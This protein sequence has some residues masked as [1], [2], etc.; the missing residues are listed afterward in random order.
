MRRLKIIRSNVIVF[1]IIMVLVV[2]CSKKVTKP[3]EYE[4]PLLFEIFKQFE[5]YELPKEYVDFCK[6]IWNNELKNDEKIKEN[7]WMK[8]GYTVFVYNHN[9]FADEV[10]RD[11]NE[12]IFFTTTRPVGKENQIYST[13]TPFKLKYYPDFEAEKLKTY[14]FVNDHDPIESE[15]EA[16]DLMMKYL[17]QYI[18]KYKDGYNE[19][20]I[21]IIK[22]YL[23]YYNYTWEYTDHSVFFVTAGDFGGG[24]IVNK[25]SSALDFLGSSVYMGTGKRYFPVDE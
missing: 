19:E 5:D 11:H 13:V 7:T 24:I 2:A 22:Y 10:S 21:K 4:A 8:G 6:E 9:Y 16:K 18:E 17:D 15:E 14:I 20:L 3:V 25:Q 12:L 23:E 1:L